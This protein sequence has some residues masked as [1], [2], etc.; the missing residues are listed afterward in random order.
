M[1][2]HIVETDELKGFTSD[3]I[4][5]TSLVNT[6]DMRTLLLHLAAGQSV[7]PCQMPSTVLYYVI[8]G[9]GRLQVGNEQAGLRTGSL[10]VVPAGAVR[11][12]SAAEPMRVLAIQ[13]L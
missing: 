2:L 8:A 11:T 12:I 5:V 4:H 13:R 10:V 1:T 6:N 3:Q 7:A 9:Q